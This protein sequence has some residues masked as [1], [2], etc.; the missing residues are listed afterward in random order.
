MLI[1]PLRPMTTVRLNSA[2]AAELL[3]AQLGEHSEITAQRLGPTT[4]ELSLLGSF[5]ADAMTLTLRLHLR[6]WEAAAR[7]R[8]HD[9]SAVIDR[10]DG[11]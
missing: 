10:P 5:N 2:L 8:G 6:A 11:S 4:V 9:V 7:A 1:E 3:L